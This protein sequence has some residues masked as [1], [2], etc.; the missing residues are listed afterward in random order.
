LRSKI[1]HMKH[2]TGVQLPVRNAV[3][4][5]YYLYELH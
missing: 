4:I 5:G 1:L 2:E 3:L